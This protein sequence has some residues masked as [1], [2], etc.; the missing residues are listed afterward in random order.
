M[1]KHLF[2]HWSF[3]EGLAIFKVHL[4]KNSRI[5]HRAEVVSQVCI[6][7]TSVVMSLSH[8]KDL[9][10]CLSQSRLPFSQLQG[11]DLC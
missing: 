1:S 4:A 6:L 5:K 3:K 10:S 9:D 8:D 11:M 7:A 2:F